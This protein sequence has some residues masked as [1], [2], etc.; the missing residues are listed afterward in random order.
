M[1]V[2]VVVVVMMMIMT[3]TAKYM[4]RLDHY[5]TDAILTNCVYDQIFC[6][7]STATKPFIVTLISK[8]Q[9]SDLCKFCNVMSAY[10]ILTCGYWMYTSNTI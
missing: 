5:I 4:L 8:E 6:N 7:E 1:M 2:V 10:L 3:T 9:C